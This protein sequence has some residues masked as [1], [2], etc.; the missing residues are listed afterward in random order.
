M[1][2][3]TEQQS[4]MSHNPYAN[5]AVSHSYPMPGSQVGSVSHYHG[6]PG[7]VASTVS[8]WDDYYMGEPP[9]LEGQSAKGSAKGLHG[10]YNKG[11]G[12][13]AA[14]ANANSYHPSSRV[15]QGW[16]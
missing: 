16:T 5:S 7:S 2:D 4:V 15:H 6:G 13:A 3:N 1:D 11:E 10:G 14:N 8:A 12:K 9:G